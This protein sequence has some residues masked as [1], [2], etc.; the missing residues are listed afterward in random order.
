MNEDEFERAFRNLTDP[1][2]VSDEAG[3]AFYGMFMTWRRGGFT[4][5]QALTLVAKWMVEIM[6][7][8]RERDETSD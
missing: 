6:K 7:D 8:M 4:E 1:M 5:D 2:T 3:V